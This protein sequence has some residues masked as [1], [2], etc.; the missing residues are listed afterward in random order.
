MDVYLSWCTM[1]CG[2]GPLRG[3]L[4]L[5]GEVA[6]VKLAQHQLIGLC[7]ENTDIACLGNLH[8]VYIGM[9]SLPASRGI[10]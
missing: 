2:S 9:L 8:Y 7:R 1:Y 4:Q 5:W 3:R 10:L 6:T